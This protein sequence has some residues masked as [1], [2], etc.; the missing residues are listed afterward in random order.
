[1]G[2]LIFIV[3]E[4]IVDVRPRLV[5]HLYIPVETFSGGSL[6]T[7]MLFCLIDLDVHW[8]FDEYRSVLVSRRPEHNDIKGGPSFECILN[9][10]YFDLDSCFSPIP[11]AHSSLFCENCMDAGHDEDVGGL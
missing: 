2:A 8:K 1:M 7:P 5:S 4:D 3:P 6:T 9:I 11:G 10:T